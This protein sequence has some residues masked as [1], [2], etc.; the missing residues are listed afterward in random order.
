MYCIASSCKVRVVVAE[1]STHNKT[2][3]LELE[4]VHVYACSLRLRLFS[5]KIK[6]NTTT[7][8]VPVRQYEH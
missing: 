5:K 1:S 2:D 8:P 3:C 4:A 6:L 7:S